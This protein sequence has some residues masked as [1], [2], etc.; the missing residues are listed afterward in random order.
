MLRSLRLQERDERRD[1]SG[2]DVSVVT[3]HRVR[4]N[5]NDGVVYKR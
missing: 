1:E 4:Q 3:A 5:D 2:F